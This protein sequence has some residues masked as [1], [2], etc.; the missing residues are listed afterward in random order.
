MYMYTYIHTVHTYRHVYIHS[1][2]TYIQYIYSFTYIHTCIHTVQYI[3]M[4]NLKGE[5]MTHAALLSLILI[6]LHA[7]HLLVFVF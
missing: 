2:H 7:A 5:F 4:F 1:V 6:F 3:Y